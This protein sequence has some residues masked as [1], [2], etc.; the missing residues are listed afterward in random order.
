MSALS[1]LLLLQ[2]PPATAEEALSSYRTVIKP[3]AQLDCP[4]AEGEEVVVCGRRRDQPDPYRIPSDASGSAP[5]R[6][7][8]MSG[9]AAMGAGGCLRLCQS[10]VGIT[11]DT[12]DGGSAARL[13]EGVK[14]MLGK[15]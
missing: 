6:G 9:G 10:S 7:E 11:F 8:P 4:K 2:S 3:L 15:D 5:A 14:R 13:A 12:R 1:L